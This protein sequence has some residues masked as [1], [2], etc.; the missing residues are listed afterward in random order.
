MPPRQVQALCTE[1]VEL[2]P[3]SQVRVRP[4]SRSNGRFSRYAQVEAM[5]AGADGAPPTYSL[6]FYKPCAATL[7]RRFAT[8]TQQVEATAVDASQPDSCWNVQDWAAAT[9][10]EREEGVPGARIRHA[11]DVVCTAH[12]LLKAKRHAKEKWPGAP[13]VTVTYSRVKIYGER[14]EK[15]QS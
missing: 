5:T 12:Q 8:T 14:L 3:G 2:Q 1:A 15:W 4:A 7:K 9:P 6:R 13:V 10:G 11:E